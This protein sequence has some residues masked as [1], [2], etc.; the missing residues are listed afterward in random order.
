MESL[1]VSRIEQLEMELAE[2][3]NNNNHLKRCL[4]LTLGKKSVEVSNPTIAQLTK[5]RQEKDRCNINCYEPVMHN[6]LAS[7]S[8]SSAMNN[9][10][11]KRN[12]TENIKPNKFKEQVARKYNEPVMHKKLASFSNNS[13]KLA[14]SSNN[15]AMNSAQCTRNSTE[16]IKPN[17]S[18]EQVARKYNEPVMHNKFSSFSNNGAMS[19]AQCTG[20]SAVNIKFNKSKEQVARKHDD[21]ARVKQHGYSTMSTSKKNIP[22]E[23]LKSSQ[24]SLNQDGKQTL[25]PIRSKE[26]LVKKHDGSAHRKTN[27]KEVS[28]SCQRCQN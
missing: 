4:T 18:K 10:Q 15:S 17:K 16:N 9:A 20:N 1:S 28:K 12:S 13:A 25:K 11:C 22:K 26:Q 8:N 14:S 6:K 24:T 2:E 5:N 27:P 23:V 3:K 19:S 21:P 7:S